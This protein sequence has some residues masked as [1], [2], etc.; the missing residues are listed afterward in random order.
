MKTH[1]WTFPPQRDQIKRKILKGV[2]VKIGS[3]VV[4]FGGKNIEIGGFLSSNSTIP[5]GCNSND[6]SGSRP[7]RLLPERD[8]FFKAEKNA[9]NF[10]EGVRRWRV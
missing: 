5:T 4:G 6:S 2:A 10:E 9:K 8:L 1:T 3:M 7:I